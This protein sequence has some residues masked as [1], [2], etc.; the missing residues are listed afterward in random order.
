MICS[1]EL[2]HEVSDEKRFR[3]I[4]RAAL[5]QVRNAVGD[6]LFTV[7]S[8]LESQRQPLS[9]RRRLTSRRRKTGT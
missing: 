1:Q 3:K 4:P 5:D 2:L 7:S 8:M 9:W 6:G